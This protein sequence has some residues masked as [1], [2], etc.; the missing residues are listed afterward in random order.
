MLLTVPKMK[1]IC[2]NT[3]STKLNL[4]IGITIVVRYLKTDKKT[5]MRKEFINCKVK[6]LTRRDFTPELYCIPSFDCFAFRR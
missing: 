2:P 6:N 1:T 5:P 3:K 4:G